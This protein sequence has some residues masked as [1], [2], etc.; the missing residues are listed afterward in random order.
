MRRPGPLGNATE[1][2][3]VW[4]GP[5]EA[6]AL[7]LHEESCGWAHAIPDGRT[8]TVEPT[9]TGLSREGDEKSRASTRTVNVRC[10]RRLSG[11]GERQD[12]R[13]WLAAR[14]AM[15]AGARH[16]GRLV[17]DASRSLD[18]LQTP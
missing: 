9:G 12:R 11:C 13:W 10:R 14:I 4:P 18:L 8:R 1:I 7:L 16:A 15:T 3:C 6:R 2:V 17:V 5:E